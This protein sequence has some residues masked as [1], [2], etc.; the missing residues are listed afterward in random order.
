MKVNGVDKK[1]FDNHYKTSFEI[2]KERSQHEWK[3]DL[4]GWGHLI[5]D[6]R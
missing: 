5:K 3:T 4:A 2:W 6:D 1:A